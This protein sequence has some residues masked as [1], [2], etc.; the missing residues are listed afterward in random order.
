MQLEFNIIQKADF[1][2]VYS[3]A[4]KKIFTSQNIQSSFIATGISLYNPDQIIQKLNIQLHTSTLS[5]S[6]FSNSQSFWILQMSKNLCQLQQQASKVK[7]F[8]EQDHTNSIKTVEKEFNQ[9]LKTCEHEMITASVMKKQYE[10]I[11]ASNKKKKQKHTQFK[12]LILNERDFTREEAQSLISFF[13]ISVKSMIN[14]LYKAESPVSQS[15]L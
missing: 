11:F 7:S 10:N 8:L 4:R 12:K 1:L 14:Q 13:N 3:T 2:D 5:R 15:Q 6:Q 9:I